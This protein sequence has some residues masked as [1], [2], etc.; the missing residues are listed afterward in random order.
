MILERT[1]SLFSCLLITFSSYTQDLVNL[2]TIDYNLKYDIRYATTN[3]FV[4]EV[5][6]DCGMCLLRPEAAQAL[7]KANDYFMSQG[8]CIQVFDCYRPYQVQLKLWEK[9][10]NAAYV[11]NPYAGGSVHNRGAAVDLTLITLD[12]KPVDFGTDYDHFGIEAHIDNY[13]HSDEILA[14]RRLLQKGMEKH[15]FKVIRTEWWH[16]SYTKNSGYPIIDKPLPCKH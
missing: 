16:F 15:G 2:D 12:G 3:N 13:N 1:Y 8:Y 9:V 14:N 4:E 11:A 5:I 7:A 6:Y 10:P